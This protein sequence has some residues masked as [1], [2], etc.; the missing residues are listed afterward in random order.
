[1][2]YYQKHRDEVLESQKEYNKNNSDSIKAYQA[3]YYQLNKEAIMLTQYKNNKHKSIIRRAIKNKKK[4]EKLLL[5]E[6]KKAEKQR[7]KD[8][9]REEE[10]NQII[11]KTFTYKPEPAVIVKTE[12][13]I[14]NNMFLL[15]F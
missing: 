12:Y 6:Q 4:Q 7:I 13:K 8:K 1:M 14:R 9:K 5:L 11:T 2:T 10:E 15:E 3:K